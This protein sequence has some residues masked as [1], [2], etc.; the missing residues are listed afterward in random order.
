MNPSTCAVTHRPDGRER[1]KHEE[2]SG[3]AAGDKGRKQ[4]KR[5]LIFSK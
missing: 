4:R 2:R 3:A 1:E 5:M